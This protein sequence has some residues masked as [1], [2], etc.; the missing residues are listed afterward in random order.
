MLVGCQLQQRL[1]GKE[2]FSTR[3]PGEGAVGA[4]PDDLEEGQRWPAV[5][6]ECGT[7]QRL[8]PTA[9]NG[10]EHY[11]DAR[12]VVPFLIGLQ[13]LSV[14]GPSAK[15]VEDRLHHADVQ[16]EHGQFRQAVAVP[17]TDGVGPARTLTV[18]RNHDHLP[19]VLLD[20]V[21]GCLDTAVQ[22]LNSLAE[23]TVAGGEIGVIGGHGTESKAQDRHGIRVDAV[24]WFRRIAG[25]F[26]VRDDRGQMT[27]FVLGTVLALWLF[28]GIVVDGGL[29][30]AGKARALDTAQE[31]ARTGAQ[32][33]DV[34]RLRHGGNVKL[35]T[36][37]ASAA[38]HA[39]ITSVGDGGTVNVHGDTVTVHV[40]HRQ[41]AQ[42]LQLIGVHTLTVTATATAQAERVTP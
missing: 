2:V 7:E 25:R 35:V 4:W 30:L 17:Q 32:Q 24:G 37:K 33:L 1:S 19:A 29:A 23:D 31:A 9:E 11:W 8:V 22:F 40:T 15:I 21:D 20:G 34:A 42:I 5:E 18:G 13:R 14:D 10:F 27:A 3:L 26:D 16:A 39:Y 38:A 36:G 6:A 41:R 12:D 28:A